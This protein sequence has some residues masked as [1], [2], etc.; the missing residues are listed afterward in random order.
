MSNFTLSR[1]LVACLLILCSHQLS[2]QSLRASNNVVLKPNSS[3]VVSVTRSD[4]NFNG[5]FQNYTWSVSP[6]TGVSIANTNMGYG[7]ENATNTLTFNTNASGTYTVTVSR[8]SSTATTT[9]TIMDGTTN[10]WAAYN[11]SNGTNRVDAFNI[12]SG[13]KA[14]GPALLY[15]VNEGAFAA[16]GRSPYPSVPEGYFYWLPNTSSNNG[17][18]T[19]YGKNGDGSGA[20]QTIIS[21]YDVNGNSNSSLGYVRLGLDKDGVA[22]IVTASSSSVYLVKATP[23]GL[24]PINNSAVEVVDNDVTLVGGSV[25]TFQNGDLCF[26]GNGN[27]FVLVNSG[28]TTQIFI[29]K[30]NG[31]NTTL[32]KKWDILDGNGNSFAG[33][34]NGCCFDQFGGMYLSTTDNSGSVQ[35]GI[36][37]LDPATINLSNN[38]NVTSTIRATLV[39]A[40]TGY[41]DLGTN[42]W[43]NNTPLPVAFGSVSASI[44]TDKKAVVNWETYMEK[45]VNHFEVE[46]STDGKDYSKVDEQKTKTASLAIKKYNSLVAVPAGAEQLYFRVKAVDMDGQY[47]YSKVVKVSVSGKSHPQDFELYP[48]PVLQAL[49]M[50]M[51]AAENSEATIEIR[52]YTGKLVFEKMLQLAKG[53]NVLD[54]GTDVSKL[55]AGVYNVSSIVDGVKTSRQF[56]KQ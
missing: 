19:M 42:V 29:G 5:S 32:T 2:A 3:R 34:V 15:E 8:G 14:N 49:H 43:P 7:T 48:N 23:N 27:M 54:L 39:Y 33:S 55:P 9:I 12:L 16:L 36:Y 38:A 22:W 47:E 20:A 40:A 45:E 51:N 41:T 13:L 18:F 56:I 21:S 26:D 50:N 44:N 46:M 1:C 4:G 6:S 24:S 35:D 30:P 11:G 17:V 28:G 52:N 53:S 37:Y 25:S 10:F 31:S